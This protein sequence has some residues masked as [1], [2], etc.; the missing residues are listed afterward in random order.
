MC[1][2]EQQTV[3]KIE[4]VLFCSLELLQD[5]TDTINKT[6]GVA[7]YSPVISPMLKRLNPTLEKCTYKDPV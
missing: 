7:T 3:L 5:S 1:M 2:K 6:E 4:D